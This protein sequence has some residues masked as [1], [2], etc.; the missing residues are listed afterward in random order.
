MWAFDFA[1]GA[2]LAAN[3]T[4]CRIYGYARED[5][6]RYSVDDICRSPL[7]SLL[8]IDLTDSPLDE[9]VW[10]RR[11]DRSTFQ[12][13]ISLIANGSE[14]GAAATV[15]VH[16]LILSNG[17]ASLFTSM[18]PVVRP[19]TALQGGPFPSLRSTSTGISLESPLAR[20]RRAT[21]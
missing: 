9:T 14:D 2:L 11:S 16:P 8:G 12:T 13:E 5:L 17:G 18:L 3:A 4:A 1:S 6:C 15:L 19:N 7:G 10:H 21:G 20:F